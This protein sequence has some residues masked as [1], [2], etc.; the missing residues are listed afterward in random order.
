[1]T[2]SLVFAGDISF[3]DPVRAD[4]HRNFYS[5][6]DTLSHVAHY[7]RDADISFANLESPIV[8]KESLENKNV[9]PKVIFLYAEKQSVSALRLA[10]FDVMTIANNHLNDFGEFPVNYTVNTLRNAGIKAIGATYGP[11]NSH[12]VPVI[13]ER[14]SLKIGVLAYCLT[15]GGKTDKVQ[16]CTELRS[17]FKGGPAIYRR[18]VARVDVERLKARKVDVIVILM[19]WGREYRPR[20]NGLQRRIATYLTSLGVHVIIGSHPH[21]MQPYSYR[22]KRFV[23]YSLGNLLFSHEWTPE[24]FRLPFFSMKATRN[25][26]LIRTEVSRKGVVRVQY[27]PYEIRKN[28]TNHCLQPIP[29]NQ[30]GWIDVCGQTDTMCLKH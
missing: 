4:V 28:P 29:L 17:L 16:N 6:K 12:Q 7:V 26:R 10:G 21:V 3:S 30:D 13:L 9:G 19:H 11:F 18:D 5:Y 27:L 24:K 14:K 15:H 8:P 25:G 1:E 23:A 20:M 2:V 22:D